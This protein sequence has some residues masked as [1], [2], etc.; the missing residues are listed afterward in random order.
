[1]H[2]YASP[3]NSFMNGLREYWRIMEAFIDYIHYLLSYLQ[4]GSGGRNHPI[5]YISFIITYFMVIKIYSK[6]WVLYKSVKA[7]DHLSGEEEYRLL[8]NY[9]WSCI[10]FGISLLLLTWIFIYP[11]INPKFVNWT[12][13]CNTIHR[14][15]SMS[16]N[17]VKKVIGWYTVPFFAN[18]P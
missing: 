3:T 18:P 13:Y 8:R 16:I 2:Q 14:N 7:N 15:F 9:L 5:G 10:L 6:Y 11:L 17:S 12:K 4:F 1:M